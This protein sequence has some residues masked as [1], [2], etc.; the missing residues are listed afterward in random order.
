MNAEKVEDECCDEEDRVGDVSVS[1]F[2]ECGAEFRHGSFGQVCGHG[3]KND[4]SPA[5]RQRC[6]DRVVDVL[7]GSAGNARE[8]IEI[9]M[10]LKDRVRSDGHVRIRSVD[11]CQHV[12]I[13]RDLRLGTRV[14]LCSKADDF[15]DAIRR[16]H[17]ALDS[18]G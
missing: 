17:D 10:K 1:R 3:P 8:A 5:A 9:A 14:R 18:V 7:P 12:S 15:S 4:F 11:C 13:A 16:R 2:I 6:L